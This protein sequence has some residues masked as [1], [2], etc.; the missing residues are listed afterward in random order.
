MQ[1]ITM[2]AGDAFDLPIEIS[3]E[4]DTLGAEA[5]ESV[6][7]CIGNISKTTT[8]GEVIYDPE[9]MA[10]NV[11]LTQEETFKLRGQ[12]LVQIR[13]KFAN[14]KVLGKKVGYLTL[15]SSQSKAV[16]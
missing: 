5:F 14:G 10:Y 16:L 2:M 6:E 7:V 4:N 3:T 13:V 15:N 1:T 12:N 8:N 11:P 9:S